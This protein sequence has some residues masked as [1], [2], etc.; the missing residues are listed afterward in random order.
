MQ[1][2]K[3]MPP[4]RFMTNRFMSYLI[5]GLAKQRIPDTQC[6]FRLIKRDVLEKIRLLTRRYET[7]SEILIKAARLG[8][9]IESVPI[10][11]IYR[12]QKSQIRPFADTLRF[13]RF[14]IK[15]L[16]TTQH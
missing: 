6:G 7:E 5:S 13:F 9:K 1:K 4:V 8:F 12:G 11:T 14:I 2:T 16:W 15:E 3:T 10:K